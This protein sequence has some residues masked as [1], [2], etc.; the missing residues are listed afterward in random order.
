MSLL[1]PEP[2]KLAYRE[3]PGAVSARELA[4]HYKLYLGYRDM[5]KRVDGALPTVPFPKKHQPE[6]ALASMLRGQGY[7]LA[8]A[9]LHELYFG[10]LEPSTIKPMILLDVDKPI[11]HG[12]GGRQALV[13]DMIAAGLQARGW[14]VLAVCA[15]CPED[16]RVFAL[17]GH[18]VGAAYGYCPLLVIDVYEHAYWMDFGT[19]KAGY[20]TNIMRYVNWNAVDVR[21][22]EVHPV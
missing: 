14:V 9:Y 11:E 16:L 22:R 19:D 15:K 1:A 18:D 3:L 10:N 5:L 6:S 20:L 17:D 21:Y 7:A 13:E 4:E 8:G 12:W 2:I